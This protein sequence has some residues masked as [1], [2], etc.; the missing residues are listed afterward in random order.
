LGG[1][2]ET[3]IARLSYAFGGRAPG[4]L[5]K[6]C[7]HDWQWVFGAPILALV[8]LF[9]GRWLGEGTMTFLSSTSTAS[10]FVTAFIVFVITWVV[11][12][13][14]RI[15]YVPVSINREKTKR[16]SELEE[17]LRIRL[18]VEYDASNI[19][20]DVPNATFGDETH[21]RII[22]LK[23]ENGGQHSDCRSAVEWIIRSTA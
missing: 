11:G 10:V 21:S 4:K 16:I 9:G 22:R 3:R 23:V 7:R 5:Q 6:T 12:F 14:V 19:S 15:F 17:K 18:S 2:N 20:C 1:C 8:L 13:C